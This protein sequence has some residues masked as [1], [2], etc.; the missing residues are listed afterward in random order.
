MPAPR[1]QR[2]PLNRER[3]LRAAVDLAD[4]RGLERLSMRE[5]GRT[6]GVEAMSLYNHVAN[7]DDLLDGMVDLVIDEIDVPAADAD[8]KAAMRR[9]AISARAAFARHPWAVRLVD[10]RPSAGPARLR[11]FEATIACLRRSG[12]APGLAVD[13][14]S[15]LD[16]FVYGFGVHRLHVAEADP[17]DDVAMAQ[18]LASWLPAAEYPYLNELIVEHVLPGGY[19]E[20]ASFAFGLDLILDG[21]EARLDEAEP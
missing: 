15:T 16:G 9:R 13:T 19:D 17:P 18:A 20:A 4:E 14:L 2:E 7:K 12:F 21:L 6:L 5:L 8:W 3:V 10:T 11:Y 1:D